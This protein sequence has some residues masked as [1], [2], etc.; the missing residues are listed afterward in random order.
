MPEPARTLA[1]QI[2]ITAANFS[3]KLNSIDR[4]TAERLREGEWDGLVYYMLQSR[5]FTEADPIE[6]ARSA[7][8]FMQLRRVPEAAKTRIGGFLAAIQ[9]PSNE[10]QRHFA[11]LKPHRGEIEEHYAQSMRFL[12][13][14]EVRCRAQE[15]PQA[16][17][18]ELYTNRGLSSDTSTQAFLTVEAAFDWIRTN[19]PDFKARRV[20]ILGPG[21]DFSPRTALRED[22]APRVYQPGQ[23][24]QLLHP[25]RV[26]CLD[27][28]P[29]VVGYARGVCD[30]VYSMNI[31]TGFQE[32]EP[33]WDLIVATNVL[34]YLDDQEL[35]LA[36]GNL[37]RMLGRSGLLLHN[38][39]R[40][41][42]NVFGKAFGLPVIRFDEIVLDG[43]RRPPLTDRY[44]L[45]EVSP[46]KL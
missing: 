12:Y 34:L 29:L 11:E 19:R 33:G 45:H 4:R 14:K 39:A 24:R 21:V 25:D 37:R 20:L 22:E 15:S 10:R 1:R 9:K 43:N 40:F 38:D 35:F 36:M 3:E 31:A 7:V 26:D 41:Q 6:P 30:S 5:T 27:V 13:E 16:C 32:T 23:L 8:E 44:V 42:T 18:A 2:G 46:P 17:V 28:N